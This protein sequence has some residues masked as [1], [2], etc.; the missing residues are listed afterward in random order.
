LVCTTIWVT[1][2]FLSTGG[3]LRFSNSS[4]S[5]PAKRSSSKRQQPTHPSTCHL[6]EEL[7]AVA[8]VVVSVAAAAAVLEAVVVSSRGTWA[9]PRR[10]SRWASSCTLAKARWSA[11]AST[12][13][14][15]TSTPRSSSRTRLPL[16][17]STKFLDPSTRF[18]SPSN[19]R[20]VSRPRPSRKVTSSTSDPRSSSRWRS[21]FPSRNPPQVRPRS[22]E[23][24][25]EARQEVAAAAVEALAVAEVPRGVAAAAAVSAAVEA[26]ASVVVAVAV[27]AA[28]AVRRE[29]AVASAVVGAGA[30]SAEEAGRLWLWSSA[31]RR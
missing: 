23:Q 12:P 15:L 3:W 13:R 21:S 5:A 11:R 18:T 31:Q 29:E 28:V 26:V 25:V 19:R 2:N 10:F 1:G 24:A 7:R 8:A 6:D 20:R 4:N 17:R 16:A 22:S 30:A 14:S 9:L 27:S